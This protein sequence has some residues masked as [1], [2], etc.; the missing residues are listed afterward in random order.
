[1]LGTVCDRHPEVTCFCRLVIAVEE[2]DDQIP[3][4]TESVICSQFSQ[5]SI[6][7]SLFLKEEEYKPIFFHL[8]LRCDEKPVEGP[9]DMND[10][11]YGV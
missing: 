6:I 7:F 10:T 11:D 8:N 1:M 9:L 5:N 4:P 2:A 3:F